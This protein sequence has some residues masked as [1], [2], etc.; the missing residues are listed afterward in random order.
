[1]PLNGVS[2]SHTRCESDHKPITYICIYAPEAS[3]QVNAS[4]VDKGTAAELYVWFTALS[5]TTPNGLYVVE[6]K[7][8][9]HK[10]IFSL[11]YEDINIKAVLLSRY[12]F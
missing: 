9:C 2:S 3:W 11:I 5:F 1:M 12:T 7:S 4:F 10:S 6:C 8:C